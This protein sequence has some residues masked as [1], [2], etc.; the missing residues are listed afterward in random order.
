MNE[1]TAYSSA[2]MNLRKT[3]NT[4]SGTQKVELHAGLATMCDRFYSHNMNG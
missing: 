1:F 2:E 3:H 4:E